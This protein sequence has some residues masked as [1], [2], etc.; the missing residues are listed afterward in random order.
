M[1][2]SIY[3]DL[4]GFDFEIWR[5]S[6]Y[7]NMTPALAKTVKLRVRP[8]MHILPTQPFVQLA[9]D[10]PAVARNVQSSFS[11]STAS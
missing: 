10:D 3:D 4:S 8:S 7:M 5:V 9:A 11:G 2:T 6:K 1:S